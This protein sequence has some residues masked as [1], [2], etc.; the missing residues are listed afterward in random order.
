MTSARARL[1]K[2]GATHKVSGSL[3]KNQ[4][5]W[6]RMVGL[7]AMSCYLDY[8]ASGRVTKVDYHEGN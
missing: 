8:D 3:R 1:N 5:L 2:T 4:E 7:G 6:Q